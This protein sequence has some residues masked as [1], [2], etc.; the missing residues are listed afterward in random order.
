MATTYAQ[1]MLDLLP[2]AT[3]ATVLAQVARDKENAIKRTKLDAHLHPHP[4][5]PFTHCPCL[6]SSGTVCGLKFCEGECRV[7]TSYD[8]STVIIAAQQ[9]LE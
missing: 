3:R 7:H 8:D 9:V 1:Q 6:T 4:L 5:S 2:P